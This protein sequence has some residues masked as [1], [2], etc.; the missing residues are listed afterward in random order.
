MKFLLTFLVFSAMTPLTQ[1]SVV[2]EDSSGAALKDELVI[3]QDLHNREYEVLR[4]LTD[5]SG[6]IPTIDFRP[7][8]YRAIATTPYGPWQT[9]V[10]EF[11]VG[12]NPV[13]LALH[14]RPMPSHGYGDIVTVGTKKKKLKVLTPNGQAASGAEVYVRD[15]GATLHL[16]RWYKTNTAG[17]AEIELTGD[18]TVV[19]VVLGESLATREIDEKDD[20]PTVRLP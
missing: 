12:E 19:V 1:V 17:E 4:V 15:R 20:A 13:H 7:G 9:E 3:V 6:K 5:K 18:P 11:L 8:L 16:E 2:V 14:V 10:Q